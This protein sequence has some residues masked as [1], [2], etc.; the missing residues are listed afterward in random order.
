MRRSV[1]SGRIGPYGVQAAVVSVHAAADSVATTN[2]GRIVAY[3]DTLLAMTSSPVVELQ[4]GIAVG[5]RDGPEAALAVIDDLAARGDLAH[6]HRLY[7]ARADF[8]GRLGDFDHAA[9]AYRRAVELAA[10]GPER[11]YLERR[12]AEILS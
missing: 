9:D 4:R 12:L 5:M 3:Y 8:A 10:Q 7:A 11:R 1:T 6:Y 2:W